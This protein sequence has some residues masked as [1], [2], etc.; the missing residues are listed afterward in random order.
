M[1][2][3]NFAARAAALMDTV[4]KSFLT[5]LPVLHIEVI[6]P[7]PGHAV[8]IS[9]AGARIRPVAM[10]ASYSSRDGVFFVS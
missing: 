7:I 3:R 10:M 8:R 1:P 9:G 2:G 4:R 5:I 6:V